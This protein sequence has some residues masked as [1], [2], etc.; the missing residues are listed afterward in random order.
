MTNPVINDIIKLSDKLGSRK[1]AAISLGISP[2]YLCD[3][4]MGRR[5]VSDNLAAK[6]GWSRNTKW[7]KLKD[8]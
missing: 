3:V 6:L 8:Y 1:K 2:Q 5:D 7:Q 4:V